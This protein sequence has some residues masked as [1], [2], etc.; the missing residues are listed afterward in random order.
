MSLRFLLRF[1]MIAYVLIALGIAGVL[2]LHGNSDHSNDML[3]YLALNEV[4]Q[5]QIQIADIH[6]NL[7]VKVDDIGVGELIAWAPDGNE[8]AV[9]STGVNRVL[10]LIDILDGERRQITDFRADDSSFVWSP[11]GT[12]IAFIS[13]RSNTDAPIEEIEE[14]EADTLSETGEIIRRRIYVMNRDGTNARIVSQ[15]G[16]RDNSLAWSPDGRYIA[17]TA[18]TRN[19]NDI[20]VI[21]LENGETFNLTD[22][23][24]YTSPPRWSPNSRHIAFV[25][26]KNQ[27]IYIADALEQTVQPL[28]HRTDAEATPAW[29]PDGTH[30]AF[31]ANYTGNADIYLMDMTD[32]NAEPINLTKHSAFDMSPRW[33]LDGTQIAFVSQRDGRD[34]QAIYIMDHNGE[35]LRRVN[36]LRSNNAFSPIWRP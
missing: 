18:Y 8:V 34:T 11:D 24:L 7:S 9:V 14:S 16:A 3:A 35:N 36:S 27:K 1:A 2:A 4:R 19:N 28:T 10:Y 30:L 12:Q 21:D 23:N 6:H 15:Y 25:S 31:A 20:H 32:T 17:F 22:G 33:S 26:G 5:N 29:S 13:N